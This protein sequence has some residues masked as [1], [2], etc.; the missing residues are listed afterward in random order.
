MPRKQNL[1]QLANPVT[2]PQPPPSTGIAI[3]TVHLVDTQKSGL[4][5]AMKVS[6]DWQYVDAEGDPTATPD[7]APTSVIS[8]LTPE[9]TRAI[10]ETVVRHLQGQ[11]A[12]PAGTLIQR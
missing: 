10:L 3:R 2:Q 1:V 7:G 9:E 11:N 5:G 4:D 8:Y 6:L 12:L